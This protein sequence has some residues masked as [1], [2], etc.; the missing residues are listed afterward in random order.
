M[1]EHHLA[2]RTISAL[3]KSNGVSLRRQGLTKEQ[4]RETA[5]LYQAGRSLTWIANHLGGFSPTTIARTLRRMDVPLRP[6]PGLT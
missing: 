6:R 4:A 5:D 2:K 1:V 3:L